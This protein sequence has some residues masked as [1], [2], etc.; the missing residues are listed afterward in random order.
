MHSRIIYPRYTIVEKIILGTAALIGRYAAACAGGLRR[1]LR[2]WGLDDAV[3]DLF[4]LS[5]RDRGNGR[6]CDS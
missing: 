3:D 6:R 4:G 2:A 5:G 1:R